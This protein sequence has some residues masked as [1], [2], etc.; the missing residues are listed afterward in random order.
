[1]KVLALETCGDYCSVAL[2]TGDG[3]VAIRHAETPARHTEF[4]LPACAALCA[5]AGLAL[6]ALDGLAFGA[7]P[8]A[9]TG[10]RV[11]ASAAQGLALAL[12]LPVV[13][14]SSLAALARGGWRATGLRHQVPV[15]DARRGEVYWAAY[16]LSSTGNSVAAVLSDRLSAPSTLSLPPG[17]DWVG[18]GAGVVLL[19]DLPHLARPLLPRDALFPSAED[20]AALAVPRFAEGAAQPAESALPRYLREPL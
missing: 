16:E 13:S 15:L 19:G 8:G 14:V 5:E 2:W 7:G 1:M 9:F 10:V 4:L 18:I 3:S 6:T 12:D 17:V 20:V 11:A